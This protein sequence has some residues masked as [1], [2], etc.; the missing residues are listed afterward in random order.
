MSNLYQCIKDLS[1]YA[2]DCSA[3]PGEPFVPMA[4]PCWAAFDLDEDQISFIRCVPVCRESEGVSSWIIAVC[5]DDPDE[6]R[7][8]RLPGPLG[9]LI[10]KF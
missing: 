1:A 10:H 7:M 6:Q 2:E 8:P 4:H 5:E 3:M 9:P